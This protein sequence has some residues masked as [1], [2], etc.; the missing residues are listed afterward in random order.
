[1]KTK[2][3]LTSE[4]IDQIIK[5]DADLLKAKHEK[6]IA[7]LN[8]KLEKETLALKKKYENFTIEVGDEEAKKRGKFDE[9]L[10]IKRYNEGKP[11]LDIAKEIG[12]SGIYLSIMKGRLIRDKKI[13]ERP[14]KK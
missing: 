2:I 14:K 9:A 8:A 10:F 11:M 1:M 5:Q 4:Q 7:S 13:K 3:K 6:E 12:V